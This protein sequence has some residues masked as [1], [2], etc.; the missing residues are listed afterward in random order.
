MLLISLFKL[1][2]M[3]GFYSLLYDPIKQILNKNKTFFKCHQNKKNYIIKNFIK[4]SSMFYIFLVFLKIIMF[5]GINNFFNNQIIR[6]YGAIY[7]GNDLG[8]LIMVKNLPKST[9]FHHIVSVILYS[10]VSYFDVEE[11]DIVKMIAVYTVFSFI[12]YS[13]NCFLAMRF[14]ITKEDTKLNYYIDMNR[15]I[16]KYTYLFTCMCNWAIHLHFLYEKIINYQLTLY[17]IMYFTFLI[18]IVN[19]DIVL[20]KWLNKKY[21]L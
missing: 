9:K 3:A 18:P 2:C 19:D 6:N 21:V 16:A 10:I 13:V 1:C 17:H 7:V 15:I 14:F 11:Y 5:Y 4:T 20:L 12:P 8:G